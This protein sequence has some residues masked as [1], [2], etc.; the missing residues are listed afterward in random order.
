[1]AELASRSSLTASG[2]KRKKNNVTIVQVPSPALTPGLGNI[3]RTQQGNYVL[4][5]CTDSELE[6][7]E[8]W[9]IFCVNGGSWR[10]NVHRGCDRETAP[11][12]FKCRLQHPLNDGSRSKSR[13]N[14]GLFCTWTRQT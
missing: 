11:E 3:L 6:Y 13:I 7:L 8:C 2:G 9:V 12:V 4:L 14:S 5:L 1:M 10:E